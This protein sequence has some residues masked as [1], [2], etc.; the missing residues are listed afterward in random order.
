M[1]TCPLCGAYS[2]AFLL[3][4]LCRIKVSARKIVSGRHSFFTFPGQCAIRGSGLCA[5]NSITSN[6]QK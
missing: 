3:R 2:V 6:A 4:D 1:V 5:K